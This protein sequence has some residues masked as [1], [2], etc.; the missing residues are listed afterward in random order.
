[1]RN[2]CVTLAGWLGIHWQAAKLRLKGIPYIP[3]P[4]TLSDQDSD[5]EKAEIK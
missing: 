2:P 5:Q 3:H 4:D 1:M